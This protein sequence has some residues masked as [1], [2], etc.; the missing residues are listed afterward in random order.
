LTGSLNTVGSLEIRSATTPEIYNVTV[1]AA[2]SNSR[3]LLTSEQD[4]NIGRILQNEQ[5][6]WIS[7]TA[8]MT[9]PRG[10]AIEAPLG[11][12]VLNNG[13]SLAT[14]ASNSSITATADG[15]QLIGLLAA[16]AQVNSD[17][18]LTW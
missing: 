9:A 4:L 5:S 6:K 16:G 10:I 2:G 13:S 12:V 18:T 1:D 11:V 14:T 3:I 7:Q 17:G 15:I 8:A